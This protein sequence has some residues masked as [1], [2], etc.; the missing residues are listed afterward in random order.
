GHLF[1]DNVHDFLAPCIY[2][3]EGEM[4]GMAFFKSIVKEHGKAYFEPIGRAL[5]QHKMK[6]L[7]PGNPAHLWKLR[8][9]LW[10][11]GK[12][13][14]GQSFAG[15]DRAPVAGLAPGLQAHVD[16]ARE[17]FAR[18]RKE[19]SSAMVKHQVKLADRQ[20][21][22]T[23]LSQRVQDTVTMLVTALWAQQQPNET[24]VA[25]ADL[26]CQDLRRK[27]TGERPSDRYFRD[28]GRLADLIL[29]GGFEALTGVPRAEVLR[30]YDN[31]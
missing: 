8:R 9:E 6:G 12:W 13:R 14:I 19:I 18:L 26:L 17:S 21:R 31:K 25:A 10:S 3:G 7:S 16:F 29:A 22:M 1:G 30:P 27:L 24:S 15:R 4:L 23:E 5:Q 28:V 11:Y 2:E 20:C